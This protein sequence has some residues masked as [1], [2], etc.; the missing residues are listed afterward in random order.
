[1]IND[2]EEIFNNYN[3]LKKELDAYQKQT[4]IETEETQ[5]L[6]KNMKT[7]FALK[8]LLQLLDYVKSHRECAEPNE[9]FVK[10]LCD[11]IFI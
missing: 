5:E 2:I 10:Q 7:K 1:M 11:Y 4:F 9:N 6:F 8:I 3:L